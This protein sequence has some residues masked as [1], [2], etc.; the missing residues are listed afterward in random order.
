ME[1]IKEKA[2]GVLNV[3]VHPSL[4]EKFSICCQKNYKTMSDAVR[5]LMLE[6]IK[7]EE[8]EA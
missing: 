4:L 2:S 7:K 3:R 8:D 6:Y 1:Q 5:D